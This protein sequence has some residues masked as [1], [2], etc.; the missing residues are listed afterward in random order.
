MRVMD[1]PGFTTAVRLRP[2]FTANHQVLDRE[3]FLCTPSRQDNQ[4]FS[5]ELKFGQEKGGGSAEQC[6]FGRGPQ[7]S[8]QRWVPLD[9][10]G[11]KR[12]H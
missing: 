6:L 2:G 1:I 12:G 9:G 7:T 11:L 10:L 5:L 8:P 3:E 4:K